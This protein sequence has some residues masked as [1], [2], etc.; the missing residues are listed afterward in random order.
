[1]HI[2]FMVSKYTIYVL[3]DFCDQIPLKHDLSCEG[4]F[5]FIQ[6]VNPH[7]IQTA[8][9]RRRETQ[10]RRRYDHTLLLLPRRLWAS[11]GKLRNGSYFSN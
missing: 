6:Q 8:K 4:L 9:Q 1:M 3:A 11:G 10:E 5:N 7:G 2:V